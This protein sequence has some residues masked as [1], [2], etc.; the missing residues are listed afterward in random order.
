MSEHDHVTI[1]GT[2]W[3]D[4]ESELTYV[5]RAIAA[6][7]SRWAHVS[8]LTAGRGRTEPDG[9]F[10]VEPIG[11]PGH[12]RWPDGTPSGCVVVD[13]LTPEIAAFLS[14]VGVRDLFYLVDQAGDRLEA[15]WQKLHLVGGA[16]LGTPSVNVYV[17]VNQLAEVHRHNGLGFTGY[18]L[19]LPGRREDRGR[20][21]AV[22][23]WLTAAFHDSDVVV[24]EDAVAS[25]WKGRALR[26]RTSV[27]SRMDLWRLMAHASVCI[28]LSPG[29]HI[30]RECIEAL[31]FG[32]PIA[33]PN[34]SGPAAIHAA[35]SEGSIFA[36]A[37]D[38]LRGVDALRHPEHRSSVSCRG[39]RYAD[40][41]FGDPSVFSASLRTAIS[42]T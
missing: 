31:R 8:V 3:K 42:R 4:R 41:S 6:A 2:R 5:T 9:A 25:A 29:P 13:V 10:D 23:A 11:S 21:P 15:S 40:T 27:D 35:A 20:P 14:N 19:V 33:V 30:A 39:R 22:V 1:L 16:E 17:P 37:E 28:D 18:Q 38:L 34:S 12:Y 32:T 7:A 24:V 36:D 26:G